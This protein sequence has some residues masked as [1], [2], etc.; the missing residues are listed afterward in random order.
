MNMA[1][2]SAP[3]RRPPVSPKKRPDSPHKKQRPSLSL[4]PTTRRPSIAVTSSF[5]T[6][7]DGPD[8]DF[9]FSEKNALFQSFSDLCVDVGF[10]DKNAL[11]Q[12]F[13]DLCLDD[14][15]DEEEKEPQGGQ[16]QDF[17]AS[18]VDF[19]DGNEFLDDGEFKKMYTEW[20]A[21]TDAVA[22][23]TK[24]EVEFNTSLASL[25]GSFTDLLTNKRGFDKKECSN[26]QQEM[27]RLKKMRRRMAMSAEFKPDFSGFPEAPHSPT[28]RSRKQPQHESVA[29]V[30]EYAL[31]GWQGDVVPS[32]KERG[33][34]EEEVFQKQK[35]GTE[36][37][38]DPV[39]PPSRASGIEN[40]GEPVT[41][42]SRS[43]TRRSEG[44]RRSPKTPSRRLHKS[45][46][47][48]DSSGEPSKSGSTVRRETSADRRRPRSKPSGS[49]ATEDSSPVRNGPTRV[50]PRRS[51]TPL[52][53]QISSLMLSP[54]HPSKQ[55][56]SLGVSSYHSKSPK[57]RSGL[58][59]TLHQS[60]SR[61]GGGSKS[62]SGTTSH[63]SR[64]MPALRSPRKS[65][66]TSGQSDSARS[67]ITP[68]KLRSRASSPVKSPKSPRKSLQKDLL[69]ASESIRA[70]S[71]LKS[72]KSFFQ[73][74]PLGVSE[75]ITPRRSTGST[76][77]INAKAEQS[78]SSVRHLA[79]LKDP[80]GVSESITPRRSTGKGSTGR[81]NAK[82]EQ[83]PSSLHH[84]ATLH[85]RPGVPD[86]PKTVSSRSSRGVRPGS[87][88][89][90]TRRTKLSNLHE[91]F[92]NGEEFA[93]APTVYFSA[94]KEDSTPMQPSRRESTA[95][96]RGRRS[97][98][99]RQPTSRNR[100]R[101]VAADAERESRSSSRRS[102]DI[103]TSVTSSSR[104]R[105]N[106][107][108][109]ETGSSRVRS[110]VRSNSVAPDAKKSS[111]R[112]H[113][114]LLS[115]PQNRTRRRPSLGSIQSS[116]L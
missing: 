19:L 8:N 96:S 80:L 68:R 61:K 17:M 23:G 53:G 94:E 84:L 12:S 41:P 32:Q 104:R 14:F 97:S 111:G 55:R 20:Q 25:F 2:Q 98:Q 52:P 16:K 106:S 85:D 4:M 10:P 86:S 54:R 92:S 49:K 116:M 21:S 90:Q 82:A 39:I 108:A 79:T 95:G 63:T 88:S 67:P 45:N 22:G 48:D 113:L 73:K 59:A 24:E 69:G 40:R 50:S 30:L 102:S 81:I 74:D 103:A 28:A 43:P 42:R 60:S 7:V 107:I 93:F 36:N 26:L 15:L 64:S 87:Q 27:E 109:P 47:D 11:F 100:S 56:D 5:K 89:C 44:T 99:E 78:P 76:G 33:R 75:S 70:S 46:D 35:R 66:R 3:L 91:M 110:R 13:S 105:S 115:I 37:R 58:A 38:G 6:C 62:L 72:P 31:E 18:L 29:N 101:S 71:P 114:D 57:K 51:A 34:K 9:G 1:I 65:M 77:R 112:S 83:I